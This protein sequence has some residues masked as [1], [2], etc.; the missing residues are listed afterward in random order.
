MSYV[1]HILQP[2]E[3]VLVIGRLHWII[4][5]HALAWF[6]ACAVSG[7]AAV[8]YHET[9]YPWMLAIAL[10]ALFFLFGLIALIRAWWHAFTT[11]IA[12]TTHRVIY[13][14]GFITRHTDEMNIDKIES[15]IVDQSILGRLLGYG[16][17]DIRG[18]GAS[19]EQ[20][21]RIAHAIELRN[22]ITSR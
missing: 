3:D 1:K 13:K 6:L 12:V 7:A 14:R 17:L 9:N 16:T 2:G 15:V 20:L 18:T 10:T 4:Y 21:K 5:W 19:I 11:E 22:A 8:H